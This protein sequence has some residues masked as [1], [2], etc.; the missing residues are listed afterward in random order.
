MCP[1]GLGTHPRKVLISY[2]TFWL[3]RHHYSDDAVP[4]YAAASASSFEASLITPFASSSS[5]ASVQVESS[6]QAS[7]TDPYVASSAT[8]VTAP[9]SAQSSAAA[10]IDA[11]DYDEYCEV[12]YVY[13]N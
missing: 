12:Q 13:E 8:G 1:I 5:E 6:A 2:S 3:R 4:S 10:R 7:S 9:H 11:S